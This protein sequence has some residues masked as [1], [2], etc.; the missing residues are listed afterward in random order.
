MKFK[1]VESGLYSLSSNKDTKEK[2]SA[3]SYLTLVQ[4]NK[5]QFTSREVKR[6]DA[7]REFR[8][9]LGCPR[10]KK[11]FKL[12]ESNYFRK[13]PLTVDDAKRA[14]HIY[15]PDKE[16]LKGKSRRKKHLRY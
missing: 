7:A 13:C 10:Y 11:Y 14:L 8:K 15:G 12:L 2:I 3:Y 9:H 6:A 5:S 4:A 16:S 1:E